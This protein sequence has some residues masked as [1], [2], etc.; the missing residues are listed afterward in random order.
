MEAHRSFHGICSWKLQSMEA[1]E[2]FTSTDS[3]NFHVL[4]WKLPLKSMEVNL[5]PPISMQV[6]LLATTSMEVNLLPWKLVETTM[7]VD[8]T[9]VD[10]PLW[11]SCRSSW[12]FVIIVEVGGSM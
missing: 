6:N 5:L 2:S 1:M 10:G 3:A 11:K 12:K 7:E 9:E 4:P 8:R